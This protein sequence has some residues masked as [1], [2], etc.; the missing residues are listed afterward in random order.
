MPRTINVGSEEVALSRLK[1]HPRNANEGDFGAIQESVETNG[2]Y[3]RIV[4]NRRTGHI[5]AGNH[6]YYVAREQGFETLPVEWIDVDPE[7]E[8]RIVL[9]DNRTARL[10]RDDD[11]KLAALLAELANTPTGLTGTGFDG[12]D[13][14][15]LISDL[16]SPNFT[17]ATLEEQGRLDQ[18][19]PVCCPECGHEFVP[20]D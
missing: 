7:A 18:K 17:P 14:D 8:L 1:P 4:A 20:K 9:A 5:V 11:A 12:D 13:L 19:K 6:R 15:R 2:F 10:G 16:A 3:G